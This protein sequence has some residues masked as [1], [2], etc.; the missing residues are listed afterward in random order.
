[1]AVLT[2]NALTG[3]PGLVIQVV[4]TTKTDTVSYSTNS[5]ADISGLSVTIT[6]SSGTKILV[7]YNLHHGCDN[8]SYGGIKLLRDSTDICIGDAI[9]GYT[10]ASSMVTD[11]SVSYGTYKAW[12]VGN[13][14]LDTHGADGSTAVTYKLQW[15]ETSS[16]GRN[17]YLNKTGSG[18]GGDSN[19][20]MA[21]TITAMEVAV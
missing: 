4:S 6:P 2:S 18:S 16:A 7:S 15:R 21:S 19:M 17:I 5:W 12:S 8:N 13:Q 14:I 10:R 3:V 11:T 1:M 9:T 20:S